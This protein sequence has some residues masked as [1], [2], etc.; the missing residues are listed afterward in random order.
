MICDDYSRV[1]S[2]QGL[3]SLQC[4]CEPRARAVAA[5][6][7]EG[8]GERDREREGRMGGREGESPLVQMQMKE[9][10]HCL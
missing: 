8:K 6:Y 9:A 3:V 4:V 10:C 7:G 2:G 1:S 5:R